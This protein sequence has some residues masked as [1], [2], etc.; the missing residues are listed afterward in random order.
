[1]D[2]APPEVP[3]AAL[4]ERAR[5]GDDGA[6]RALV[7]RYEPVVAATV[8]GMLGRG[9]D[10]DDVGQETFVRLHRS[11]DRFRGE[12]S[13]KTYLVRIAMNLSLNAL[14]ARRRAARRFVRDADA[15]ELAVAPAEPGGEAELRAAVRAAVGRL[16]PKHRPVVVLRMLEG[17]STR[18]TAQA[19]GVPEGT[20]LSRLSRAL[21]E[22]R[23]HLAPYVHGTLEDR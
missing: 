22:L 17:M 4:L 18:E 20:V 11:L 21:R 9:A 10:A 3:D 14:R 7:V 23:T 19:L 2:S 12:A 16:G 8:I 6:F 15:P 5:R 13:L 1:M